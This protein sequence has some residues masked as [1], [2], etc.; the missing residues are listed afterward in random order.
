MTTDAGD[1]HRYQR[2]AMRD[3]GRPRA[4]PVPVVE[5]LIGPDRYDYA[6]A[7]EIRVREPDERSAEELARLA[8]EQAP[9]QARWFIWAVQ[10]L[11]LGF[12]LGPRSSP[13]HI[14]GWRMLTSQHDVI[15]L[16]AVSP[17]LGRSLIV[18]RRIDQTCARVTI[19]IFFA[20]P[21]AAR[22]LWAIAGPGHRRIVPY[23]M[24]HAAAAARN[25]LGVGVT[26]GSAN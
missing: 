21:L 1:P 9:W 6:D 26:I 13:D 22:V 3:Q 20:H 11:L 15:Q 12:R 24:E 19:C 23:V 25:E 10:R 18:A 2:E 5:P 4:R 17:V 8:F 14:F 7:Y 16:G